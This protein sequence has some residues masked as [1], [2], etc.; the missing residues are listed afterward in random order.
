MIGLRYK[1]N[2][3]NNFNTDIHTFY[4]LGIHTNLRSH[5]QTNLSLYTPQ[6]L[7][8]FNHNIPPVNYDAVTPNLIN[9]DYDLN[10]LQKLQHQPTYLYYSYMYNFLLNIVDITNMTH[11]TL[12]NKYKELAS[13]L[14]F[15]PQPGYDIYLDNG[16]IHN[17]RF[18]ID[19][20]INL[21]LVYSS[22]D[23]VWYNFINKIITI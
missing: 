6:I 2:N 21:G 22:I 15:N 17:N 7:P 3:T 23:Y 16:S 20:M 4:N 18:N 13:G 19:L 5:T 1:L 10:I 12:L 11:K 8:I 14:F 9:V